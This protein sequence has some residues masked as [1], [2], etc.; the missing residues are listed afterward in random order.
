LLKS[1]QISADTTRFW[2]DRV[3]MLVFFGIVLPLSFSPGAK[4]VPYIV[5]LGAACV[6]IQALRSNKGAFTE[7]LCWLFFL[8]PLIR[9]VV[10]YK[11]DKPEVLVL[12]AP[13]LVMLLPL[14]SLLSFS[15]RI[16][17]QKTAPFLYAIAAVFYGALI[18]GVTFHLA[19]AAAVMPGWLLPIL[20]GLYIYVE[21]RNFESIRDG[22]ERAMLLGT[23][24]A[25]VYGVI[26]YFWLPAWDSAWMISADMVSEGRPE[27]MEV[28]V[29]SIM[30]S[31]QLLAVFLLVGIILAYV[32]KSRWK[33][34]VLAAGFASL[35]LS[36]ARS[37]WV[38]F[39]GAV[40]YLTFRGSLK[41]RLRV[42]ALSASCVIV[43]IGLT[44]VPSLSDAVTERLAS[45]LAPQN[46]L[47]AVDRAETYGRVVHMLT[48]RP[49]GYGMGVDVGYAD[50][51]HDSSLVNVGFNLGLPGGFVYLLDIGVLSFVLIFLRRKGEQPVELGLKASL[52]GLLLEIP[53]NNV[54]AGQI[55]FVLWSLVGILYA[56]STMRNEQARRIASSR[57]LPSMALEL[58]PADL[59]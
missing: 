2:K 11:I 14:A 18:A 59:I 20:W 44:R 3:P 7:F 49:V 1:G 37:S 42:L 19:D 51:E 56:A 52:V 24:V 12:T 17:N 27:P 8:T 16:I 13:F 29:F 9:R 57:P 35:I 30:N 21:R 36:S 32:S 46:D 4:L 43:L 45:F 22:F 48:E 53:A 54:V 39:V 38:G 31:S 23:F 15:P 33:Y 26:Q 25:G 55:A 34:F 41:E 5:P 50:A 28:R 58:S 6:G 40:L 47:S 10:D